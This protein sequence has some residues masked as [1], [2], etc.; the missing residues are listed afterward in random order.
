MEETTN[1]KGVQGHRYLIN[2]SLKCG[3][4]DIDTQLE[5]VKQHKQKQWKNL[6]QMM[7]LNVQK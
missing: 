4:M 3:F 7:V 1:G 2:I 6:N 5:E